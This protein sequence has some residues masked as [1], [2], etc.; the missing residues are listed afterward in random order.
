MRACV[1]IPT[2]NEAK[3]IG[4]LISKIKDQGLEVLVV[5]DGSTDK[6]AEIARAAKAVVLTNNKNHGKGVALIKGFDYA[7][8]NDFDAVITMD[9]D[10]Q[11]LPYDIPY[12]L[13]LAQYSDTAIFIGNR[14]HQPKNMPF[15]RL[16]TN[17]IMSYFISGLIRQKVPDSQC[18]FRLIKKEALSVLG[19]STS[20]Y[21]IE[22]EIL[23]KAARRGL[24][25][26]SVPISTVY[27][28]Q[29]SQINPFIDSLRFIR[30]I[31]RE[32]W[33]TRS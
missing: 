4:G 14:M 11:H 16:A 12:F 1:V 29:K 15:T 32:L 28:G 26:E 9:G 27:F 24:K 23:I 13:R 21:E 18:G 30:Y 31:I 17:R 25:I 2:Y 3:E 8:K 6:T 19:L 5:D 20:N 33:I 22:T 10:G 7:I